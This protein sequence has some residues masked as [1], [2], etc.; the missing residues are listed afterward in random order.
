MEEPAQTEAA[1]T[2]PARMHGGTQFVPLRER[3]PA[4]AA[5]W[6]QVGQVTYQAPT[7]Q[8]LTATA[9]VGNLRAGMAGDKDVGKR[10]SKKKATKQPPGQAWSLDPVDT[11][12]VAKSYNVKLQLADASETSGPPKDLDPNDVPAWRTK[13]CENRIAVLQTEKRK[14]RQRE[15]EVQREIELKTAL[16]NRAAADLT[17]KK[18]EVGYVEQTLSDFRKELAH[19]EQMVQAHIDE[20]ANILKS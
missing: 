12:T 11:G 15:R 17:W 7:R 9:C 1:K 8:H 16:R 4:H 13:I 3:H 10:T 2:Q 18:K 5:T 20:E 6:N 19:R 14:L